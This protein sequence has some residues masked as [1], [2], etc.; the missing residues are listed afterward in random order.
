MPGDL[1]HLLTLRVNPPPLFHP[2]NVLASSRE[3]KHR[4]LFVGN[5]M[6]YYHDMPH[7][8]ASMGQDVWVG[9]ALFAGA[10]MY[11]HYFLGVHEQFEASRWTAIV[12]QPKCC[13]DDEEYVN[14]A[15]L[16][17]D[18][19]DAGITPVLHLGYAPPSFDPIYERYAKA[20]K[21]H[22]YRSPDSWQEHLDSMAGPIRQEIPKVRIAP[23]GAAWR[24]A[25]KR[26]HERALHA[27]DG[28]HPSLAGQYL[29]A[30]VLHQTLFGAPAPSDRGVPEGLDPAVAKALRQIARD[31]SRDNV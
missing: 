14:A 5:S 26:G 25:S 21:E 3:A 2:K 31:V 29:A 16:A 20:P 24:L 9:G 10:S 4:V 6:T 11:D 23:I 30:C 18:A 19:A 7:I 1:L 15:T 17:K 8:L 13:V 28:I 27:E 22:P 12:F